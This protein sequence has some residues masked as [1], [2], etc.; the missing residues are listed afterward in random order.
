M[1]YS[2]LS[3][4][5]VQQSSP[6]IHM[7]IHSFSHIILH[8]VPLQVIKYIIPCATEQDLIAEIPI[9]QFSLNS[10]VRHLVQ[11]Q[12]CHLHYMIEENG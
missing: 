10:K 5:A 1:I 4:S 6:V 2:V 8:H 12:L 7:Y 9:P 11:P 3:I